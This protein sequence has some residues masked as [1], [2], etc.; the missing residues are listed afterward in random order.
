M[1]L[2]TDKDEF[3]FGSSID[4]V[5]RKSQDIVKDDY[6]PALEIREDD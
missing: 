6:N 4:E 2:V 3:Q 1:L 5:V